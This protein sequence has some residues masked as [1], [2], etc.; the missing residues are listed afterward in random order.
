MGV[1]AQHGGDDDAVLLVELIPA[2]LLREQVIGFVKKR[3]IHETILEEVNLA[4]PEITFETEAVWFHPPEE[5][6]SPV[7]LPGA[8]HA[9]EHTLIGLLPHPEPHS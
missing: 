1:V 5:A 9:L 4:L 3:Y 2:R 7:E 6:V 8:I